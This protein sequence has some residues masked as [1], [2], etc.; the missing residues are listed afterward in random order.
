MP[1]RLGRLRL[2]V[3]EWGLVRN[4]NPTPDGP[5]VGAFEHYY[6]PGD[7]VAIGR[8]LHEL[9]RSADVIGLANRPQTVNVIGPSK[10]RATSQPSTPPQPPSWPNRSRPASQD[11]CREEPSEA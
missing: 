4:W 11:P 1:D 7:A 10:P 9:L 2:A 5:R 8:G 3:D 6:S